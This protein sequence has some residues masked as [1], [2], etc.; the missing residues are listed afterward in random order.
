MFGH[1]LS[2]SSLSPQELDEYLEKGWYRM[3]QTIFTCNFLHFNRTFFSAIW[4][5]LRLENYTEDNTFKKLQKLNKA[6]K[7]IIQP[8]SITEEKE[9][10]FQKYKTG[11]SFDTSA[12]LQ[13]LLF[14]ES[15]NNIYN[16]H[17]VCVYD[18]N[19][20]IAVGYF[21]IGDK[22]VA[23]IVSFYD[24]EY[25]KHSLGKFLIYHKIAYSLQL[26]KTYFY[27][28]YFAPNYPLFD[29]KLGI[30]KPVLEYL[31]VYNNQWLPFENFASQPVP[32]DQIE[33]KL[34]LMEDIL[35]AQGIKA[36]TLK[37][38]FYNA[39]SIP[40]FMGL[41]LFDYPEFILVFSQNHIGYNPIIV[42]DVIE[43]VYRLVKCTSFY[44]DENYVS[45]DKHF[46]SHLMKVQETLF[47]TADEKLILDL[48]VPAEA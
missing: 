30:G 25:K 19:Q 43:Q 16:T 31:S 48:F 3:G 46:G 22:S 35:F 6:F 8:A 11:I 15:E 12:S 24:P 33:S 27:P 41:D 45:T 2:P 20:L 40:H 36:I 26:Q 14:G 38:E 42:F 32:I 17:E 7:I 23:G 13:S 28:G 44:Q 1:T 29:Y 18:Q 34:Q 10:L 39:N 9:D 5:K 21:D 37:Y 47:V 4:L